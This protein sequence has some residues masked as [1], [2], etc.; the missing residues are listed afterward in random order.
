[1][2]YTNYLPNS[3]LK[4]IYHY[5]YKALIQ[6]VL[7]IIKKVSPCIYAGLAT[8]AESIMQE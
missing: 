5:Y 4:T 8:F 2:F 6:N 7:G 1:M 3:F